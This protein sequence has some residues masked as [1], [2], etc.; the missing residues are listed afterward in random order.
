MET[1]TLTPTEVT[2][3]VVVNEP[4]ER[5]TITIPAQLK[6]ICDPASRRYALNAVQFTPSSGGGFLSACDGKCM[7]IVRC[8][9]N[10]KQQALIPRGV[11]PNAIPRSKGTMLPTTYRVEQSN[12]RWFGEIWDSKNKPS[13]EGLQ[14][15]YPIEGK[16]PRL[17]DVVPGI[18]DNAVTVSL[19]ATLLAKVAKAICDERGA[20]TL[21]VI[22]ERHEILVV[23]TNGIGVVMNMAVHEVDDRKS[24]FTKTMGDYRTARAQLP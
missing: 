3:P 7:A 1:A 4:P 15:A 2:P 18:P 19:D 5:E 12:G 16:Y 22:P 8:T 9:S 24:A 13:G 14:T 17:T 23:G 21:F 20:I 6:Q 10:A 11:L